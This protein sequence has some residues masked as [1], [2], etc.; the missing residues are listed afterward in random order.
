MT[1]RPDEEWAR[2]G[3]VWRTDERA[4]PVAGVL[5][6]RVRRHSRRLRAVMAIEVGVTIVALGLVWRALPAVPVRTAWA[7]AAG[8]H[9]LIG[10]AFVLWNRRGIW[11][12]S[13]ETTRAYVALERER[14]ERQV[15]TGWFVIGLVTVEAALFAI[16]S[17][18]TPAWRGSPVPWILGVGIFGGFAL[19]GVWWLV[20]ARR[21]RREINALAE[22]LIREDNQPPS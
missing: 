18:R 20:R 11:R 3:A 19:W 22:T 7:V 8:L 12:P 6:E 17:W 4:V 2:L 16:V 9:S 15:R 13:A 5:A 21:A 1:S 10:W 14:I